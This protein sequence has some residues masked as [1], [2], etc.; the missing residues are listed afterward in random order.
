MDA[1]AARSAR[2]ALAAWAPLLVFALGVL[3]TLPFW[4]SDL[5]LRVA[6]AL[7][8]WNHAQGG[9]ED[10]RWWWVLAYHLPPV[11]A[12]LL[13][14]GGLL[15]IAIGLWKPQ[16]ASFR[17]GLYIVLVLA[18]GSGLISN[19][20][21]KDHWG[22]PRPRDTVGLGGSW[23]YRAPWDKGVAGRGKSFPCGHATVP[24]ALLALWLLWRRS[25]PRWA[26]AA[27]AATI[28]LTAYVSAARM[29]EQAHWLSD[30]LWAIVIMA[31]VALVLHRWLI[32]APPSWL[33]DPAR[34][35]RGPVLAACAVG[36][37]ALAGAALLAT[38]FYRE[39][40]LRADRE[41]LGSGGWELALS[42]PEGA[43]EIALQPGVSP[44]LTIEGSVRGFGLPTVRVR[45]DVGSAPGRAW[46]HLAIEG[47][48]SEQVAQLRIVADP[49][50]LSALR[51]ASDAADIIITAPPQLPQPALQLRTTG[52]LRLPEGWAARD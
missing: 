40:A 12:V 29:V 46:A 22:R 31:C 15:A 41:Q 17:P 21:L 47:L 5:D 37:G 35:P 9:H 44:T 36:L 4:L 8:A 24:A 45:R 10:R 1:Q 23:E 6:H 11:L 14:G 32:A 38:P 2:P 28:A 16:L 39:I 42:A 34:L 43:I 25:R 30:V 50:Q 52:R 26:G 51:V 18:L 7:L 3:L 33:V 19:A 13:G 48:T 20:V 27:L 49:A